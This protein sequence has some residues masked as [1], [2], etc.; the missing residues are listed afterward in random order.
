LHFTPK[1][2]Y[3]QSERL[4]SASPAPMQA[5]VGF[6]SYLPERV[7]TNEELAGRLDVTPDWILRNPAS[8]RA[9]LRT[10]ADQ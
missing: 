7:L 1:R 10:S 4:F 6:G 9:E 3:A 8:A 5:I 2:W